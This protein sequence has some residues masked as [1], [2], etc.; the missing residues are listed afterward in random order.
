MC[1]VVLVLVVLMQLL[2][3]SAKATESKLPPLP[4][5]SDRYYQNKFYRESLKQQH[6]ELLIRRHKGA[7]GCT[8]C[9]LDEYYREGV[10]EGPP[11]SLHRLREQGKQWPFKD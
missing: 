9:I 10:Y 8:A 11:D 4:H 3:G 1:V 5:P 7:N 2:S 6:V